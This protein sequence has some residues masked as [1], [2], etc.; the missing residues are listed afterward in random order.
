MTTP[1]QT[2]HTPLGL[3]VLAWALVGI[4]LLYG[5]IQTIR[6]ASTLFTG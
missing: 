1:Q 4:P 3:I 5:L 2:T 6:A